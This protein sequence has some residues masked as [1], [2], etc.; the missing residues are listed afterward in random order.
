MGGDVQVRARAT[1]CR[2]KPVH[3]L[4]KGLVHSQ[5]RICQGD[6]GQ[7]YFPLFRPEGTLRITAGPHRSTGTG[8]VGA[9]P[10]ATGQV[11]FLAPPMMP[12]AGQHG[13]DLH[14]SVV[15]HAVRPAIRPAV[16]AIWLELQ[17]AVHAVDSMNT[18]TPQELGA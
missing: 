2:S 11:G 14:E 15:R 18:K 8:D 3:Q 12:A 4:S 7:G 16:Q 10:L 5:G 6:I 13:S 17:E 9:L 1:H